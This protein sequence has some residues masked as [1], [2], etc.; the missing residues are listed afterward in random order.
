MVHIRISFRIAQTPRKIKQCTGIGNIFI[1]ILPKDGNLVR[2][3]SLYEGPEVFLY[4][5][6]SVTENLLLKKNPK[7]EQ[8]KKPSIFIP[9]ECIS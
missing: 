2:I 3:N 5:E 8:Q 6:P 1:V 9:T 4:P 7:T